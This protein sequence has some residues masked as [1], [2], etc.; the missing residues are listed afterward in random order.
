MIKLITLLN[1]ID[2]SYDLYDDLSITFGYSLPG[3]DNHRD[4]MKHWVKKKS[5]E[6]EDMHGYSVFD[7]VLI[8]GLKV[9]AVKDNQWRSHWVFKIGTNIF[10]TSRGRGE[11]T[12]YFKDRYLNDLEKLETELKSHD[13]YSEMSDDNRY[14][15]SG[16]SHLKEL[17][18]LMKK[19]KK[20]GLEKE[21]LTLW[22]GHAPKE[23]KRK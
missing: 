17:D 12:Q 15:R 18:D 23:F 13:W 5:K 11:L 21:S 22:N 8:D 9:K 3:D 7:L 1:E 14:V 20:Q 4:R 19:L 16:A 10:N 6:Y 2:V